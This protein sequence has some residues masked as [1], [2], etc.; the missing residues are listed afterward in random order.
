MMSNVVTDLLCHRDM[1]ED[2]DDTISYDRQTHGKDKEKKMLVKRF[3]KGS[4]E[5]QCNINQLGNIRDVDVNHRCMNWSCQY[6]M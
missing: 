1:V 6:N 2:V 5:F 3:M 4:C